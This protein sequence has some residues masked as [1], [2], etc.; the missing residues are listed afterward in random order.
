[1]YGLSDKKGFQIVVF[2][3]LV[4]LGPNKVDLSLN[5]CIL[6]V[7]QIAQSDIIARGCLAALYTSCLVPSR[8]QFDRPKIARYVCRA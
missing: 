4:E 7:C 2:F 5:L 8:L 1:M 3:C 6:S